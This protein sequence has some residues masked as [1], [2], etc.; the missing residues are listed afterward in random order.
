MQNV[1]ESPDGRRI[2]VASDPERCAYVAGPSKNVAKVREVQ[3]ILLDAGVSISH[4]WT[5]AVERATQE[6]VLESDEAFLTRC[7]EVDLLGVAAARWVVVVDPMESPGTLTELGMAL[8]LGTPVF[9]IG[10]KPFFGALAYW[11]PDVAV[12]QHSIVCDECRN[13]FFAH[14]PTRTIGPTPWSALDAIAWA[15]HEQAS[16]S[17]FHEKPMVSRSGSVD[18]LEVTSRL[19]LVHAE[20]SEA[21]EELR[22]HPARSSSYLLALHRGDSRSGV[23]KPEGFVVELADALIRILDLVGGL[24]A[25]APHAAPSFG[26]VAAAKHVYNA[27]RAQKHGK[28]F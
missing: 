2:L 12:F 17:G 14:R 9:G 10:E 5:D 6:P 13:L 7:A 8:G 11:F 1:I 22:D 28:N 24:R 27:T 18:L 16:T 4:D 23:G 21:L 26:E 15:V 25:Q 3:R 20:I 19:A